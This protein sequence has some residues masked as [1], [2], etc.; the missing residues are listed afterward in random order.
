M[1]TERWA[2]D[3]A[4]SSVDFVVRH[5]MVSKIRGTF[6]DWSGVIDVDLEDPALSCA[7]ATIFVGSIATRDKKRD[8][9]LLSADFFDVAN[10]PK[11]E[12]TSRRLEI[13]G[14]NLRVSGDLS[15]RGAVK[16]I[17]LDVQYNGTNQDPWGNKR[18]HYSAKVTLNRKDFGLAWN[19]ALETGGVL[20]GENVEV[21]IEIEALRAVVPATQ[22]TETKLVAASSAAAAA[23]I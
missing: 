21:E 11:I 9:H 2:I 8:A 5:M 4:H 18:I 7:T 3:T 23:H 16:D 10:H 19:Q 20:I 13:Q 1:T 12:F 22:V 14:R 17:M 6:S 15:I